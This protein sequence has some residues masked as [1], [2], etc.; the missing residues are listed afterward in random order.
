MEAFLNRFAVR[1]Y[2]YIITNDRFAWN[3]STVFIS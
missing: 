3:I 2:G 1:V